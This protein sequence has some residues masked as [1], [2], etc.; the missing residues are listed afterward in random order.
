A[1]GGHT[2]GNAISLANTTASLVVTGANTLTLLGLITGPGRLSKTGS[3]QLRLSP[4]SGNNTYSGGTSNVGGE[5]AF[6]S[7]SSGSGDT[8]TAGA[9][10]IGPI[11]AYSGCAFSPLSRSRTIAN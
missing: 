6:D 10:G 9:A 8:P 11:Y 1:G 3:G 5:I 4:T 2:V 7:N